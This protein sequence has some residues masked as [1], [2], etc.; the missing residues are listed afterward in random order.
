MPLPQAVFDES[1][2]S[3][4]RARLA[5]LRF[6]CVCDSV[7]LR[8]HLWPSCLHNS[9]GLFK[10]Q[11]SS[12]ISEITF[13]LPKTAYYLN[14]ACGRGRQERSLAN[15]AVLSTLTLPSPFYVQL[16]APVEEGERDPCR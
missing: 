10:F 7:G 6:S 8:F 2:T 5:E 15:S 11:V 14:H 13:L 3:L 12:F 4:A 16:V 9:F 1:E